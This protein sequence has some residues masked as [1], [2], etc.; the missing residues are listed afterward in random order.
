M[1]VVTA[2]KLGN[3][4]GAQVVGVD[5]ERLLDDARMPAWT[6]DALEEHG[7]LVFAE[8]APRR[9]RC[10]WRSAWS[11]APSRCGAR[12]T[13][14]NPP[15]IW[16]DAQSGEDIRGSITKRGTFDWHIN[17]NSDERRRP[18]PPCSSWTRWRRRLATRIV[19]HRRRLRRPL[20]T[21]ER[22]ARSRDPGC[23]VL[24]SSRRRSCRHPTRR[25]T[26]SRCGASARRRRIPLV[27]KHRN[28]RPLA[29]WCWAPLTSTTSRAWRSRTGGAHLDDL[30]GPLHRA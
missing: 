2:E 5:R 26:T 30:L 6:L 14:L 10:K 18:W 25:P 8:L 28:G 16:G 22:S 29:R 3:T 13:R 12:R 17:G 7:V 1:P 27:W 21:R 11:S 15:Y 19:E 24:A 23:G 4:V 20:R 9:R